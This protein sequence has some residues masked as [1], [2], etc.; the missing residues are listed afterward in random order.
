[1]RTKKLLLIAVLALVATGCGRNQGTAPTVAAAGESE[2]ERDAD[3]WS[4]LEARYD[5]HSAVTFEIAWAD[6][7]KGPPFEWSLK[8]DPRQDLIPY[9]KIR[10][11]AFDGE[12]VRRQGE[13]IAEHNV[14]PKEW[15]SGF[16]KRHPLTKQVFAEIEQRV[17]SLVGDQYH[18]ASKDMYELDKSAPPAEYIELRRKYLQD[19]RDG[20][21]EAAVKAGRD[22]E[23]YRKLR[24]EA[25][26]AR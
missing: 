1:M 2:A 18:Q 11:D 4:I 21:I 8:A 25:S 9:A 23:S 24:G 5:A 20:W 15:A 7:M 12:R 17:K 13:F 3:Y 14:D 19:H 26:G 16:E 22:L 10:R 6:K